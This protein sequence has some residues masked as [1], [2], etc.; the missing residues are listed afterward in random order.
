MKGRA[1]AGRSAIGAASMRAMEA[2]VPP[3]Q[4]LF[5]D[6]IILDLLPPS[7]RLLLPRAAV[8]AA[9]VWLL[10]ATAPGIR[11][12]L[13]CR[14][15]R[16]DDAV[17]DA[18]RQGLSTLVILG[19]GLDTRPYRFTELANVNVVEIDLPA[20][21]L[22]KKRGLLKRF[23]VLPK[24]VRFLPSD[25]NIEQLDAVLERGGLNTLEPA[26]FVWEGV[27]QYL[28][29]SAADR[30]FRAIATRPKGTILIFTYLLDEVITGVYRPDRSEALRKSARRQ[31][32]PW[33]F[34]IDPSQL[35]AFL[36]LWGLR[37]QQDFGAKEHKADYLQSVGRTLA[38]SEIERVAI[39]TV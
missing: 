26:V 29:P 32:E 10:E 28:Q 36:A 22:L 21:Q 24:H 4:R 11:G 20:V 25:L 13:L 8:R 34:G 15:R 5:E 6:Q 3:P 1:N 9:F 31:P 39:A 27:S 38:V 16:I 14:T 17:L 2:F 30:V 33:H 35:G 23:G 18:V 37:L 19:A 7:V 12:A